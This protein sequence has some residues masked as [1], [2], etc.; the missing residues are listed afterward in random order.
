MP[1]REWLSSFLLMWFPPP[2]PP[3]GVRCLAN[4]LSAANWRAAAVEL[5]MPKG[6]KGGKRPPGPPLRC[7]RGDVKYSLRNASSPARPNG[8]G[9]LDNVGVLR[10]PLEGSPFP[11]LLSCVDPDGLKEDMSRPSLCA[12]NSFSI[13]SLSSLSC[14]FK[15]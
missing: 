1:P 6:G 12:R 10:S 2:P 4:P 8:G 9:S 14:K 7:E 13:S 5:G 3:G 11:L 15:K